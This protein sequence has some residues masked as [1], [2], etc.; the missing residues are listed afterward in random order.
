MTRAPVLFLSHGSP[1]LALEDCAARRFL[2]ELGPKLTRP[3]AIVVF[4]AH[5]DAHGVEITGAAAPP[6][7]H[8]FGGFPRAL[9]E[10]RYPAP[11]D[12]QLAARCAAL[13]GA[14]FADV[15]I[16][17]ARGFDHGAWVPLYLMFPNADVPVVQVSI[18]SSAAPARHMRLGRA[19]R[20]LR[21]E[22]VLL[23]GS[24]GATHN[25]SLYFRAGELPSAPDWVEEFNEWV[26]A[27]LA[28]RRFHDLERYR[29]A[30]PYAVQN[31]PS[32]EHFLPIFPAVGATYD[33]EPG[34]RIHAS[35]DR[36]VLSLDAYA[37]GFDG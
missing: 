22:R 15:R 32:V 23:I 28:A 19:L 8:D 2:Q 30:A 20:E 29:H 10:I 11:G 24:G 37:F 18:D 33:D 27:A 31:H 25:L 14:D 7:I 3:A 26:A 5:H 13:L 16:D 17:P 12:P 6:T 1:M 9:Y 34:V 4:S 21:D 36:G 35:Y